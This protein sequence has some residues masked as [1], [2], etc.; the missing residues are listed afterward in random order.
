MALLPRC[1]LAHEL[2]ERASRG[3]PAR[4]VS[5]QYATGCFTFERGGQD[6]V[7]AVGPQDA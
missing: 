6:G 3:A 2:E 1:L 7:R 4:A 5:G